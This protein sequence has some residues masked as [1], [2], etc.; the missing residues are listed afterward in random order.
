MSISGSSSEGKDSVSI[1]IS[2]WAV[3]RA[4]NACSRDISVLWANF[5]TGWI[6]PQLL[7]EDSPT[8]LGFLQVVG[9]TRRRRTILPSAA[10]ALRIPLGDE[11]KAAGLVETLDR[12]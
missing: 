11:F 5:F 4:L 2:G 10:R 6:V 12:L 9:L 8:S 3:S 7:G 1:D